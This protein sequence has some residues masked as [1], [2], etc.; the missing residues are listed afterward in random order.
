MIVVCET[1]M[2]SKESWESWGAPTY[3]TEFT[4]SHQLVFDPPHA[5][6]QDQH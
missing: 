5:A 3:K 2:E 6:G 4:T 1:L